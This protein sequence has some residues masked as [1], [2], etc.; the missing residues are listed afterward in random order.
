MHKCTFSVIAIIILTVAIYYLAFCVR[1]SNDCTIP[2]DGNI[3]WSEFSDGVSTIHQ[4]SFATGDDSVIA[5]GKLVQHSLDNC[6]IWYYSNAGTDEIVFYLLRNDGQIYKLGTY[7]FSF[8]NIVEY[9]SEIIYYTDNGSL[10]G[11]DKD[12]RVKYIMS[13]LGDP[14]YEPLLVRSSDGKWAYSYR[15]ESKYYICITNQEGVVIYTLKGLCPIWT[16]NDNLA[17]VHA[18]NQILSNFNVNTKK[19]S[20]WLSNKGTPIQTDVSIFKTGHAILT[21]GNRYMYYFSYNPWKI[22][23]WE[24]GKDDGVAIYITDIENGKTNRLDIA[25]KSSSIWELQWID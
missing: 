12:G 20:E 15:N 6:A 2:S 10:Y 8:D 21:K 14:S 11:L 24:I 18:D 17:Y 5:N 7:N 4:Y 23:F 16:D 13:L 19:I 25:S 22:L 3:L 1:K 9:T